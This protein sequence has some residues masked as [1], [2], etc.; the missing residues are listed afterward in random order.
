MAEQKADKAI[1]KMERE[2]RALSRL[3]HVK[4]DAHTQRVYKGGWI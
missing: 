1:R 2:Q 3:L 4:G